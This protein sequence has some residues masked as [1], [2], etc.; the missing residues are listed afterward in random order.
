MAGKITKIPATKNKFQKSAVEQARK[1]RTAGYARVSTDSDEQFTSYEAQL[2]YYQTY[3][4][5][6][7]DWEFVGMYSDEGI[8]GTSTKHREGFRSMISDALDGK[9]D[10]IITK[11]VSRFARNTVDSLSTIRKLKEH[12]TEVYFEKENIWTFDSKG[13]LLITIMSSLAQEESRSISENTTWGKRK[14]FADG[15]ASVSYSRFL[16]YDRG[17]EK[18]EF[19]INEEEA[20]TVREIFRLFL[21]GYSLQAVCT[22]LENQGMKPPGG[23]EKWWPATVKS[24]VE[25]EKY[26]GDCLLQKYYTDDFLTKKL[27]KNSGEVPQYYVEDHHEPI[28]SA[29]TFDEA[30]AE[31]ARRSRCG[32]RWSGTGIFSSKIV[33]GECG[34][35]YGSKVWHSKDKYRKTIWQCNHKYSDKKKHCGTPHLDEN[36][37]KEL[38]VKAVG[39]LWS[40]REVFIA[41]LEELKEIGDRPDDLQTKVDEIS[42]EM[43]ALADKTKKLIEKNA[44]TAMDQAEYEKKYSHLVSRYE[45]KERE[46]QEVTQMLA[47]ARAKDEA[48]TAFVERL[49][50]MDSVSDEFDEDIWYGMVDT[51]TVHKDGS[52]AVRF[53][54]GAEINVK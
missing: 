49:R 48:V 31:L 52:A 36:R 22:E 39:V 44:K 20:K 18:G 40:D 43:E 46:L 24:I 34:G 16:G 53:K 45:A 13:E 27:I 11:S 5:G 4:Q 41:N 19:V 28:V 3:I 29:K 32:K 8:T 7:D 50:E 35:F 33:C 17:E 6:R 54:G 42:G 26:K 10:L 12:G 38:F 1:R 30:Q 9:I 21:A 14:M 25:N 23:G 47:A 37:I 2:D 15:K 51:M